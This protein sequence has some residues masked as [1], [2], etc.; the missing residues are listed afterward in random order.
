VFY[1]HSFPGNFVARAKAGVC[2]FDAAFGRHLLSKPM[3]I[4]VVLNAT[5]NRGVYLKSD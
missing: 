1:S 2:G 4:T 3:V 5:W